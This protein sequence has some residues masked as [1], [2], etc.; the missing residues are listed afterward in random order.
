MRATTHRG[1]RGEPRAERRADHV[2]RGRFSMFGPF[3]LFEQLG[4]GGM[5]TVHA[6][7]RH[8]GGARQRVALKRLLP[9]AAQEP[10]HVRSFLHE[11]RLATRLKHKNI[12]E[13]YEAGSI[14]GEYFIAMEL[15]AGPT[16]RDLYRKCTSVGAMPFTIVLTLLSQVCDA[17]AYAHAH[18]DENG[19]PVGLVHRDVSPS[20]I[21]ISKTGTV[22]LIDFGVAK[23]TSTH[24]Q[25][26]IIKGKLG[27]IAPEYLKGTLDH[28]ADL[29]AVGVIAWE[30]LTNKRLFAA[31]DDLAMM[32]NILKQP[33]DPP[34]IHNPDVPPDLD[35]IVMTALHRDPAERWQNAG[36]MR[37]A[38]DGIGVQASNADVVEWVDWTVALEEKGLRPPRG[39]RPLQPM[40]VQKLI[41]FAPGMIAVPESKPVRPTDM[42]MTPTDLPMTPTVPR[43][44]P[45]VPRMSYTELVMRRSPS[46]PIA[47][48]LLARQRKRKRISATLF[49]LACV[50]LAAATAVILNPALLPF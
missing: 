45:R 43:G 22:K 26:G 15:V 39:S 30:L 18:R 46:S 3:A 20:N 32:N 14:G 25:T 50:A 2:Q 13:I 33:I 44:Q 10:E 9:N 31:D 7:E 27:Y 41:V 16:L 34:S 8:I 23:S 42:T 40:H 24:T 11:G 17:L 29:W 48:A 1:Q 36:A 5:A 38:L 37:N 12:A 21:V 35:A 6:A 4:V 49:G 28:R 47:A 19:K